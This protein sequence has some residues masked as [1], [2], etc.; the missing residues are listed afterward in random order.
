M[1]KF[2]ILFIVSLIFINAQEKDN[3]LN[4][5]TVK[6]AIELAFMNNPILNQ[7]IQEKEKKKAEYLGAFGLSTPN[8]FYMKEGIKNSKFAEQRLTVSQSIDFPLKTS[9]TLNSISNEEEAFELKIE[10][11]KLSL[12]A[13]VKTNYT[14]IIYS[15]DLKNLYKEQIRISLDLLNAVKAKV[16]AGESSELDL[17]KAEIKAAEAQNDFEEADRLFHISRYNLFKAI[18]L[19]PELQKY[20]IKF[21]D[22]LEYV[23]INVGQ[24]K[25]LENLKQLPGYLSAEK[26]VEAAE[27]KIS[28]AW[29]GLLPNLN[30]SYYKQDY[31]SGF[32]FSGF[33]I[34]LQIPIWFALNN[35]SE[36]QQAS[37]IRN[38]LLYKQKEIQLEMKTSIE[39]TWHSYETSLSTIKRYDSNIRM[40]SKELRDLTLE[41]YRLGELD[42]LS[43]LDSQRTY[44]QSQKRYLDAL[45]DYYYQLV[46]LEKYL[47]TTLVFN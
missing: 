10:S 13:E 22:S 28:A 41:G 15:S 26:I 11:E 45:R 1:R 40:K 9:Y 16:E 18:G 8:I 43:L 14:D 30:F 17:M 19:N 34:G 4:E 7:L 24:L 42:L 2:I 12:A 29:S 39:H 3:D 21:P 35:N 6:K 46:N 5:L 38:Q 37:A 23:E 44:L 27:N 31:G 25:V 20:S 36:I 47:N 33:E 32:S